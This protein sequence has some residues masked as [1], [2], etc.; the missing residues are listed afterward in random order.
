MARRAPNA[1]FPQS[2]AVL[3]LLA[4]MAVPGFGFAQ[5]EVRPHLPDRVAGIVQQIESFSDAELKAFYLRCSRGALDGRMG[6][7]EIALCSTGYE[8]LLKRAF[9]GNFHALLEW[10]RGRARAREPIAS[11]F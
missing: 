6:S 9:G 5:Q 11:P 4:A 8:L 3:L 1:R 2:P 7:G 10:R